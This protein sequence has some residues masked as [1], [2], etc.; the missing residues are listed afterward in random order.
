MNDGGLGRKGFRGEFIAESGTGKIAGA[1]RACAADDG[2]TGGRER[3][4]GF[5]FV[6]DLHSKVF[7]E[8][9][10]AKRETCRGAGT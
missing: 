6:E 8:V 4:D 1:R 10:R 9:I 7:P 3:P 5:V 2:V